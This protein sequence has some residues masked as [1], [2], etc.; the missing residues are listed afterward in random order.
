MKHRFYLPMENRRWEI[1][2]HNSSKI[3]RP[4]S[5]EVVLNEALAAVEHEFSDVRLLLT[6]N[7]RELITDIS[8]SKSGRKS[9]KNEKLCSGG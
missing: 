2:F 5:I 3:F 1:E 9:S 7:Y 4:R 6:K 8:E